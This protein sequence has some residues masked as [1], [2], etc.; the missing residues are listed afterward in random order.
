VRPLNCFIIEENIWL[1]T[2]GHTKWILVGPN[3]KIMRL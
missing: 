2:S 1:A 3:Y